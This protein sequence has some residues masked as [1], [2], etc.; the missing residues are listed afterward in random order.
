MSDE[1]AKPAAKPEASREEIVDRLYDLALEPV[2]L[3]DFI[4]FWIEE[5]LEARFADF[6][7]AEDGGFDAAYGAHLDRAQAFL[8]RSDL[9]HSDPTQHL[10]AYDNLAAF[11]VGR[12]LQ[13]E[14]CN[15]GALT[16]FGIY[17]GDA[18]EQL[19]LPA[20]LRSALVDAVRSVFHHPNQSEKLLKAENAEKRGA[21]LFRIKRIENALKD[22][23]GVLIVTTRFH[24]RDGLGALLGSAFKL[25]KAEQR[26][27][28]CLVEGQDAK[29]IAATRG[30]SEG[31]VRAQIKS[32]MGKMNLRSQ[33]DI[34]R[35]TM[36]LGAFPD[37]NPEETA[38]EV[39]TPRLAEDWLLDAVWKP[40]NALS[41]PD[42]RT[43]TY[44]DMGPTNGYPVLVSH[45][46]S[47]MVRWS[48]SMI[49]R[50]FELNLR[51]ICPI[52]AGYGHSSPGPVGA[53][54]MEV[55]RNDTL[56]VLAELGISRVPYVVQGTDFPFAADLIAHHPDLISEVIGVGAR[57]CLPDGSQIDGAGRWQRFFVSGARHAPQL[58]LFASKAVMALARRL[59]PAAMLRQLCKES[60]ADLALLEV[61]EMRDVLEAN[62]TLMAGEDTNAAQAFAQEYVAFQ[63]DWS[64]AVNAMRHVPT[65]LFLALEDPTIDHSRIG[66]L[67][68][69]Y[70]WI[71][72]ETVPDAGL[73]QLFQRAA[74]LALVIQAAARRAMPPEPQTSAAASR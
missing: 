56:A 2:T 13:V 53:D 52:R 34:V 27:A 37:G 16:G 58:V 69:A 72:F 17:K 46:G 54:V 31:T 66:D 9:D 4:E 32:I 57:P 39:K 14:A 3:D 60:P 50:L 62:L 55:A 25:T 40:F 6:A 48:R 65:H 33:T 61:D 11:I 12:S 23:P 19:R 64:S 1:A 29:T 70:P 36:S 5:D 38:T 18:L 45:M 42:G 26:V 47:A 24:W 20:D 63:Q 22:G 30:T 67:M 15:P 73:A 8:Q 7:G 59:G 43:I 71:E 68:E 10:R 35:M 51:V 49:R 41:C 74:Q 21:L 28:R 44:H